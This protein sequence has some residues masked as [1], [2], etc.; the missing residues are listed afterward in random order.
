MLN[1]KYVFYTMSVLL[2]VESVFLFISSGISLI[3][4][5]DDFKF[6]IQA[7]AITL[8]SGGIIYLFTNNC[9]KEIGKREAFVVVSLV[10]VVFSIFGA[11]PFLLG[12]YIP[13]FT[14]AFFETMSGFTTTGASIIN[15][16]EALPHGILFWR[17]LTH[18]LGGMGILVLTVAILPIFG[19]GGMAMFNAEAAGITTDKLHPRIKETAQR[20]WGIYMLLIGIET[21]FLVLGKMSLFDAVCHSFGTLASGGFSTKNSSIADYS[22]YIQYVII[23]FMILAGTNFT[24][25]YFAIKGKFSKIWK[26]EEFRVFLGLI[27]VVTAI[28]SFTLIYV[29]HGPVEKSFRDALFQVTSIITSTGFV[30]ADYTAW[31]PY[32]GFLIFGLMFTGACVGSTSG[33][34]KI[35]RHLLLFKNSILEFKRMIHPSAVLPVRYKKEMVHKDVIFKILAF[36]ILYFMVFFL[37]SF[38]MTLIG[39][40]VTSSMGAVA[41]TMGGIGPGLGSVGPMNNFAAVPD[42]GKWVLSFLMLLGRLELFTVL[43]IFVPSFWKNQ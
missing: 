9:S 19:F 11:L 42:A 14:D 39:L 4:G 25:H 10:W 30:S 1:W 8:S 37:G 36:V 40:D 2:I 23:V 7:V 28:I 5:E 13:N 41:T 32:L 20:L 34:V 3:Y 33:G 21:I 6:F 16:I 27:A 17:S 22:P 18:L 31:H 29:D 35:L 43:I 24:L 12:G 15:D 26:N 38:A